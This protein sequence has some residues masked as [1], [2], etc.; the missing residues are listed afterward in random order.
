MAIISLTFNDLQHT[1]NPISLAWATAGNHSAASS[2]TKS[3]DHYPGHHGTCV[4]NPSSL[5]ARQN[6]QLAKG[7]GKTPLLFSPGSLIASGSKS[8]KCG[9]SRGAWPPAVGALPNQLCRALVLYD[10]SKTSVIWISGVPP[11]SKLQG[12]LYQCHTYLSHLDLIYNHNLYCLYCC[13]IF[14]HSLITFPIKIKP[15]AGRYSTPS[16][17]MSQGSAN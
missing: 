13:L 2:G 5:Q 7:R 9:V 15:L 3:S 17:V 11:S 14:A 10:S 12:H 16:S 8:I 1:L 6:S 4:A